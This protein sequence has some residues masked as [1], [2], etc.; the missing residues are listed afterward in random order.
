MRCAM[1]CASLVLSLSPPPHTSRYPCF[2]GGSLA[3]Q[4]HRQIPAHGMLF[5]HVASRGA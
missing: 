3:N 4:T 1:R 2:V 5:G